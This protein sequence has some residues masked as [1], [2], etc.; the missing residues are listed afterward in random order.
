MVLATELRKSGLVPRDDQG[1][2]SAPNG[3]GRPLG[4]EV[5]PSGSRPDDPVL[6][7]RLGGILEEGPARLAVEGVGRHRG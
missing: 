5:H 4:L 7:D 3:S 2:P 1:S 6:V